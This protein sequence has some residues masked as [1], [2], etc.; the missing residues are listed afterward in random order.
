MLVLIAALRRTKYTLKEL[1]FKVDIHNASAYVEGCDRVWL[2]MD[3]IIY[4]PKYICT[5][6]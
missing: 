4:L 3:G 1:M 2:F 5:L 6:D